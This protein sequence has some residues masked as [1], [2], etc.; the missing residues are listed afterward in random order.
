MTN[1]D[2]KLVIEKTQLQISR[3]KLV[4]DFAALSCGALVSPWTLAQTSDPVIGGFGKSS[5]AEEVTAGIDL[6]GKTALVTGANSGLGFETMRVLALRGAH[7]IAVARTM[8]K[9]QK[10]L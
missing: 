1:T 10:G 3:R 2:P 8:E 7:V 5:T 9:A 4:S 6:M